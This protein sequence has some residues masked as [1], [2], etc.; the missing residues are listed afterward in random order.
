MTD[1]AGSRSNEAL[2]PRF[3]D[4]RTRGAIAAVLSIVSCLGPVAFP[5]SSVLGIFPKYAW[6]VLPGSYL[7]LLAVPLGVSAVAFGRTRWRKVGLI[8]AT[9]TFA[10]CLVV[11]SLFF[12]AYAKGYVGLGSGGTFR[13]WGTPEG[14]L[15]PMAMFSFLGL[16][17]VGVALAWRARRWALLGVGVAAAWITVPLWFWAKRVGAM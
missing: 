13:K 12:Y 6:T 2:E 14:L 16:Q 15:V 4:P 3:L 5:L 17:A 10:E 7:L 9:V 11:F 1:E 8:G